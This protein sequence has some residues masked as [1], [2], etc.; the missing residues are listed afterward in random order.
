[1]GRLAPFRKI[2]L[3]NPTKSPYTFSS[4]NLVDMGVNSL[5]ST[6]NKF[7]NGA[8][9]K[10]Y[11]F[12]RFKNMAVSVDASL[13]IYQTVLAIRKNG[14]DMCN[15]NGQLTSHLYGIF[16]KI[17][18]F[19]ENH[20]IPIFVFD[21]KAPE[22]KRKTI[23]RRNAVKAAAEE[24]LAGITDTTDPEYTKNIIK[25]FRPTA[26]DIQELQ[27]MLDLMGIPYIVAPE[28]ADPVCA[29]LAARRGKNGKRYVAGVC[30]DDSDMLALG[31]PLL[32]KDMLRFMT[33]NK[34]I[35]VVSLE[36]TLV[37]MNFTM[38]QF[39]DLCVMS[40]TDYC[41]NISGI[42]PVSAY[43]LIKKYGNL[44]SA[45]ESI[46]TVQEMDVLTKSGGSGKTNKTSEKKSKSSKKSKSKSSHSSP[47]TTRRTHSRKHKSSSDTQRGLRENVE[48]MFDAQEYFM[49]ALEKLDDM[50]EF[51]VNDHNTRLR[52]IQFEELMDFLCVKHNFEVLRTKN[53][54][55]RAMKYYE[56]MNV[57]RSNDKSYH[58]IIH[59]RCEDYIFKAQEE[60]RQKMDSLDVGFISEESEN[61]TEKIVRVESSDSDEEKMPTKRHPVSA[62]K[63]PLV[64]K[65]EA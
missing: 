63:K 40:G 7:T 16:Y 51:V 41:D 54:I 8:A 14:K 6:I 53:S 22:I 33:K 46:P 28:E 27:T 43:K 19:L 23:A 61:E 35:Q 5:T 37:E 58:K 25:T 64:K 36:T 30:S 44:K 3:F 62:S 49:T 56:E 13:M 31:A 42:G 10:K 15:P 1:M 32:F 55:E 59:P 48:C 47:D 34:S 60:Y 24:K 17:I 2:E 9:I 65:S 39:V 12:D 57:V 26:A 21:G 4:L 52:K 11:K 29:W 50:D 45:L 20:M 38:A 18:A